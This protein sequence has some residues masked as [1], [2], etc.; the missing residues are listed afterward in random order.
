[1]EK[2]KIKNGKFNFSKKIEMMMIV[3]RINLP[4]N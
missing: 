3:I 1:M 2:I 4:F